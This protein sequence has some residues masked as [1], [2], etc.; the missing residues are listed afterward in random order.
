MELLTAFRKKETNNS[1]VP[2]K[3]SIGT[4][5]VVHLPINAIKPNPNQPRRYFSSDNL[6]ELSESI[7]IYGVI[8][9]ITV[10][11]LGGSLYELVSGERRLRAAIIAGQSR[12]PAIVVGLSDTD[13]ALVALIENIQRCDLSFLE[14]AEGY[15]KLLHDFGYTQEQLA[16]KLGKNQS[17]IANKVRLLKL[18]NVVRGVIMEYNLTERHARALLRLSDEKTRLKALDIIIEKTLNVKQTDDLVD[19]INADERVAPTRNRRKST[20]DIRIFTNTVKKA[21]AIISET[22]KKCTTSLKEFDDR[23]EYNLKVYK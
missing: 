18:S 1:F 9:P 19:K 16:I 5:A 15:Y 22:G 2:K 3:G 17:T 7:R 6:K 13:S 14:E 10:R 20:D 21:A 12:I 4:N 23:Y 11:R 8:Q